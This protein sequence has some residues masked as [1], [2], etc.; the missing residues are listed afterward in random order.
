M[1]SGESNYYAMEMELDWSDTEKVLQQAISI[2][3]SLPNAIVN[4]V[5]FFD[6][7]HET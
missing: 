2:I 4:V 6:F 5:H 7:D 1:W 3:S